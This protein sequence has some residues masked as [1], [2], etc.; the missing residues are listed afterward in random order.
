M[1]SSSDFGSGA[2]YFDPGDLGGVNE[3][4][5]V[6]PGYHQPVCNGIET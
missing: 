6:W 2:S 1:W 4:G 5:I 3:G